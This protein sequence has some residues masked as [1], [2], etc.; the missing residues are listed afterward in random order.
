MSD[1]VPSRLCAAGHSPLSP[2][3]QPTFSPPFCPRNSLSSGCDEK[4]H[5]KPYENQGKKH[6][7]QFSQSSMKVWD[8]S[9]IILL[10]QIHADFSQSPFC[11]LCLE[12]AFRIICSIIFP[13]AEVRL[14]SQEFP[15]LSPLALLEEHS[16]VYFKSSKN[17]WHHSLSRIISGLHIMIHSVFISLSRQ[18]GETHGFSFPMQFNLLYFFLQYNGE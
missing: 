4:L 1:W 8:L 9:T 17:L 15:K 3:A 5:Q 14:T 16:E 12:M 13:E 11:T 7:T 18:C 6:P 2:A 10:L